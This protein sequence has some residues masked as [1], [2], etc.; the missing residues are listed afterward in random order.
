MTTYENC[1]YRIA[2]RG[3]Q[4]KPVIVDKFTAKSVWVD[5]AR[6]ARESEYY[7]FF[8]TWEEAQAS[9]LKK[10][11]FALAAQKRRVDQER[12]RLETVKRMKPPVAKA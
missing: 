10:A 12:S 3:E 2:A 9:L 1:W 11:E 7:S 5:G 8:P 4:I 6:C